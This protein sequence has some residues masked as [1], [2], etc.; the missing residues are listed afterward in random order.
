[1]ARMHQS[2]YAQEVGRSFMQELIDEGVVDRWDFV[3][4]IRLGEDEIERADILL[5]PTDV[6]LMTSI[7]VF[8]WGDDPWENYCRQV[9][10]EGITFRFFAANCVSYGAQLLLKTGSDDFLAGLRKHANGIG[11]HIDEEGLK[12]CGLD[13]PMST[14]EEETFRELGLDYIDPCE[15]RGWD[16][17]NKE[18]EPK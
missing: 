8:I 12:Y 7:F 3:G 4:D 5:H 13:I 14:T 10:L 17:K 11:M 16:P 6:N 1:M 9:E 18:Y 2:V 15:R